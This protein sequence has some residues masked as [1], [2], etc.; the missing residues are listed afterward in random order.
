MDPVVGLT[1]CSFLRFP[2]QTRVTGRVTVSNLDLR[3]S[4]LRLSVSLTS[5]EV[6]RRPSQKDPLL[7]HT[8][9]KRESVGIDAPRN[10]DSPGGEE[11]AVDARSGAVRSDVEELGRREEAGVVQGSERRLDIEWV[12]PEY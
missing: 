4:R 10:F 8:L 1:F 3:S 6:R 9:Q 2:A 7:G 11:I 5:L 12:L